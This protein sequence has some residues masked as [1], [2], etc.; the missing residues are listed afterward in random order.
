MSLHILLSVSQ[1]LVS[2][3]EYGILLENRHESA[4]EMREPEKES[5]TETRS[6]V[7]LNAAGKRA[8]ARR[9]ERKADNSHV[10]CAVGEK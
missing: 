7:D 9:R 3:E 6:P 2:R 4:K 1:L 10:P 8:D 5:R